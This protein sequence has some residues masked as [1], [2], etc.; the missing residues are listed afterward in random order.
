V[1]CTDERVDLL[2]AEQKRNLADAEI[3]VCEEPPGRMTADVVEHFLIRRAELAEAALHRARAHAE[4]LRDRSDHGT[5]SDDRL[6]DRH[7]HVVGERPRVVVL[8]DRQLEAGHEDRVKLRVAMN[9]R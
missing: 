5:A 6:A 1:K 2:E 9:H 3:R 8:P 7:A 4:R